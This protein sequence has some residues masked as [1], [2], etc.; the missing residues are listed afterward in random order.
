MSE[1][2]TH[3]AVVD[4]CARLARRWSAVCP[5]FQRVLERHHEFARLGGLTRAGD[6][7][8]PRLLRDL[9]EAWADGGSDETARR[10]LAFTLG[11]LCHR[12]ADRQFKPVFRATDPDCPRSPTDCSVY[13]D[14]FILRALYG[15]GEREPYCGAIEA[16]DVDALEDALRSLWQRALVAIHTFIPDEEDV[17]GWLER[18]FAARQ[19]FRVDLRRYAEALA[20][21]DPQKVRRFIEEPGFYDAADPLIRLARDI[22][23][24]QA[25]ENMDIEGAIRSASSGSQYAGALA[26]GLSYLRA[27]SDYFERR[28]GE[29]ELRE[30]LDIGRPGG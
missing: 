19:R 30:L 27:A 5:P 29:Q 6:N 21:P 23:D 12:A 15:G 3:T 24:G 17:H 11:W 20:N 22:Q 26:R 25:G 16:R 2:V 8:T 18:L 28:V 10:K 7:H 9:R 4:D 14:A 13:H 1:N